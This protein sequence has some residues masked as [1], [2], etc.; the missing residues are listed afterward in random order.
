MAQSRIPTTINVNSKGKRDILSPAFFAFG[1]LLAE[2]DEV[3]GTRQAYFV[4][5]PYGVFG[6]FRVSFFPALQ[7]GFGRE[8][9]FV[10]LDLGARSDGARRGLEG[11]T[12][13]KDVHRKIFAERG[14]ILSFI[15]R[16]TIDLLT[17]EPVER[18]GPPNPLACDHAVIVKT[19]I[20]NCFH[21][22]QLLITSFIFH[23]FSL[24]WFVSV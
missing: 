16:F 2:L 5:S 23:L 10:V 24:G 21:D 8:I 12:I 4:H 17:V 18:L 22:L 6:F 3:F 7:F 15:R 14:I 9:D 20:L 11:K 13:K 19:L 1:F